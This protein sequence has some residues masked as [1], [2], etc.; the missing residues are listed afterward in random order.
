M[1]LL[2]VSSSDQLAN[3]F[4]KLLFPQ[5]FNTILFKLGMLNI[6]HS[7]ACGGLLEE[8]ELNKESAPSLLEKQVN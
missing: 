2:P 6:Y 3:F 8:E 1:K 7:P 4:T 5:P